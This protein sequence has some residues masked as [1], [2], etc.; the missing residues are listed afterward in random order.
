VARA[1]A[2]TPALLHYHFVDLAGLLR[3]LHEERAMPLLRPLLQELQAG[4]S[5]AGA[6]LAR[7]LQKWTRLG[8][9]HPWLAACLL[10]IPAVAVPNTSDCSGIVRAAVA[11]AQR[12]G[13]VRPD[14]P[15]HYIALLLLSLGVLP[16]LAQTALV[17]GSDPP[18]GDVPDAASLTLLHLA[19]L[20]SG[21]A[22][23]R[24]RQESPS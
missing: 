10:H 16:H 22:S 15:D 12:Q 14:L 20:R 19:L 17:A 7:F 3:G 23:Q 4:E 2:V 6:A 18:P 1:A 9:R 21:V 5:D 24:P 13:S 11:A 8:V